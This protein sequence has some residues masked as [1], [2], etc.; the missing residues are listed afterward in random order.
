MSELPK[1]PNDS[2]P[3]IADWRTKSFWLICVIPGLLVI[4]NM[5]GFNLLEMFHVTNEA[6]LADKIYMIVILVLS[7]G[8]LIARAAPNARLK[9]LGKIAGATPSNDIVKSPA[10]I[11]LLAVALVLVAGC[12]NKYISI[13]DQMCILGAAAQEQGDDALGLTYFTKVLAQGLVCVQTPDGEVQAVA[14]SDV[15]AAAEVISESPPDGGNS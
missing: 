11:G 15:P 2:L 9:F 8:G 10:V 5:L 4:S 14:E 6:E 3:V 13:E 12:A 1:G 7:V